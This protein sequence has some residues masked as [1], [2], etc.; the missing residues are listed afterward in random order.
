M[1]PAGSSDV[2][3]ACSPADV[4]VAKCPPTASAAAFA[5]VHDV[6]VATYSYQWSLPP[7]PLG[8]IVM[9]LGTYPTGAYDNHSRALFTS[10]VVP[11]NVIV[12]SDVPSPAEYVSPPP[13][14]GLSKVSEPVFTDSVT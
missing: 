7:A 4:I 11:V 8:Q 10:T 12:E 2:T 1:L 3:Y 14:S 6:G 13:G 5:C 9:R